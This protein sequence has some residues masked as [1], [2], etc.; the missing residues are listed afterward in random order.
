MSSNRISKSDDFLISS[1]AKSIQAWLEYHIVQNRSYV[2]SESSIAYP[3]AEYLGQYKDSA[4]MEHA[5]KYFRPERCDM[6]FKLRDDVARGLSIPYYFEFKYTQGGSTRK[7]DEQQRVFDDL[8]RLNSIDEPNSK[9]YFLMAGASR[10]FF[11]D[12]QY[13]TP[14]VTLRPSY[15]KK[16]PLQNIQIQFNSVQGTTSASGSIGTQDLVLELSCANTRIQ[17]NPTLLSTQVPSTCPI[18]AKIRID[19]PLPEA[20]IQPGCPLHSLNSDN[21]FNEMFFFDMSKQEKTI[22]I[23]HLLIKPLVDNFKLNYESCCVKKNINANNDYDSFINDIKN[24]KT[25][26]RYI[27]SND[28]L[29]H[30]AIWEI[31][32]A[33]P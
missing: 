33:T 14:R 13:Y 11:Q 7:Q 10:D 3:I 27:T 18:N 26:L 9:K 32:K 31:T 6:A 29:A 5:L 1:L 30:V 22:D 4:E 12:F 25:S 2:L 8:M 21:V 19:C 20:R 15:N 28:S 23:N 24:I 17:A 16:C